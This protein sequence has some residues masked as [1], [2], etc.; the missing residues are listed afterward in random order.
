MEARRENSTH[1]IL[2]KTDVGI[3]SGSFRPCSLQ[4]LPFV[5]DGRFPAAS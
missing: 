4:R 2:L 1:L 3:E 5:G